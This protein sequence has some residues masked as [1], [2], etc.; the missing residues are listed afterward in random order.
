M[1]VLG[2]GEIE[3]AASTS[4]VVRGYPDTSESTSLFIGPQTYEENTSLFITGPIFTTATLFIST[5]ENQASGILPTLYVNGTEGFV[6]PGGGSYQGYASLAIPLVNPGASLNTNH[7]LFVDGPA[8]DEEIELETLFI[9]APT[10]FESNGSTTLVTTGSSPTPNNPEQSADQTTLFIRNAVQ[11]NEESANKP[12]T[13]LFV[14]TDFNIGDFTTLSISGIG[15]PTG[16]LTVFV[17]GKF[18]ESETTDLF[19]KGPTAEPTTLY[20]SAWQPN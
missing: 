20:M 8:F 6:P 14:N 13:T 18:I 9:A 15:V 16:T 10:D 4:L 5:L 1:P 19:V 2:G 17:D 7:T 3:S 11:L 12:I